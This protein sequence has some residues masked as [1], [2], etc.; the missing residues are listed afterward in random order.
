MNKIFLLLP[1]S[2]AIVFICGCDNNTTS[3]KDILIN[4]LKA[5]CWYVNMKNSSKQN[6]QGELILSIEKGDKILVKKRIIDLSNI[7]YQD[8]FTIILQY[9]APKFWRIY[10]FS[11]PTGCVLYDISEELLK[12]CI[13]VSRNLSNKISLDEYFVKYG[14]KEVSQNFFKCNKGEYGIRL[15]FKEKAIPLAKDIK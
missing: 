8:E 2:L 11:E 6:S 5:Q 7:H 9:I 15:T 14:S 10:V 4:V 13:I 12:D 1:V 3:D